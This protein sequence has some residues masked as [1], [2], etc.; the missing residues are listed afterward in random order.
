MKKLLATL[1]AIV[2]ITFAQPTFAEVDQHGRASWYGPNFHGQT[3][4]SG[5]RYNQWAMTAAHKSLPL[6]ATVRV[7]NLRNGRFVVVEINDRGPYVDGR[8]IDL[9][10]MAAYKLRLI[11]PGTAPV[12]IE[13]L[14]Y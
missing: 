13:V 1:T 3:T 14:R 2:G 7:T 6:G 8:V 12:A 10:R 5:E 4:A 11:S 9:S